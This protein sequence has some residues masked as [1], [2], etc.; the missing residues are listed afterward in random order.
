MAV[1]K[2]LF[3]EGEPNS[4]NG[5]LRQGFSKLLEKKIPR[6]L[7]RIKLGGGKSIV[8]NHFLNNKFEAKSLLL[9][10]LDGPDDSREK[11]IVDYKLI[12]QKENVFYMVQEMES[13][14]LSQPFVLDEF[15]GPT[16]TGHKLSDKLKGKDVQQISDPKKELKTITSQLNKGERYH[17]IKH[18]VELLKRLDATQLESD[19]PDFRK[20]I[21]C[22]K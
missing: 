17:E 18:A 11:D 14:F 22:L 16:K 3:I 2:I 12:A 15:Y 1:K 13:W 10:D 21:E 6:N 7:P 20:L 4:P 9:F 8:V 19:F 5:D